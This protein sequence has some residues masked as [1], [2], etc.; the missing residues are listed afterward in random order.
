MHQG[1]KIAIMRGFD[2]ET[3]THLAWSLRTQ[4][5]SLK[6][7]LLSL[8]AKNMKLKHNREVEARIQALYEYYTTL[9]ALHEDLTGIN[10]WYCINCGPLVAG[11]VSFEE[12]CETCGYQL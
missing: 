1:R 4:M 10:G 6:K 11:E 12:R 3:E 2:S 9:K 8:Q 7:E 5:E